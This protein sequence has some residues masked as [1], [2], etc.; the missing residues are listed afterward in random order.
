M[1]LLSFCLIGY[2]LENNSQVQRFLK[3]CCTNWAK[4]VGIGS[5]STGKTLQFADSSLQPLGN[6]EGPFNNGAN[7]LLFWNANRT[8]SHKNAGITRDINARAFTIPT[9]VL[10]ITY[11]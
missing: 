9:V 6:T 3:C 5:V 7:Y 2:F 4:L 8:A 10:H 11:C 1:F